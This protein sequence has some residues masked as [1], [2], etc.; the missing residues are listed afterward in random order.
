MYICQHVPHDSIHLMVLNIQCVFDSQHIK[1]GSIK[2]Q[3]HIIFF[4]QYQLRGVIWY[5]TT[6]P[7]VARGY[8]GTIFI[9]CTS[10]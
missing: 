8:P 6:H 7:S 1:V 4:R 10:V 2:Q 9:R 3:M 5:M